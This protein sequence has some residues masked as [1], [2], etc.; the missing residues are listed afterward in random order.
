LRYIY[1]ALPRRDSEKILGMRL[2]SLPLLLLLL[3]PAILTGCSYLP[4]FPYRIDIQQGNVVTEEMIIKLKTG[5]TRSQVRFVL[6][7][8]LITDAF[9]HNRWDYIYRF[10]PKGQLMEEKRLTVFFENDRL[11]KID[12]DF[13]VPATFAESEEIIPAS[14]QPFD[15]IENRDSLL[16]REKQDDRSVDFLKQNQDDFYRGRE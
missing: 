11:V 8:P 4:A 12:G 1:L 2:S 14:A 7:S 5:M 6:G 15:S 16:Q 10:A 13:P 9:H 3:C